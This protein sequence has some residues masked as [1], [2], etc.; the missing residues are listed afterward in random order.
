VAGLTHGVNSR[1]FSTALD[2]FLFSYFFIRRFSTE[3]RL[4]ITG[5][6]FPRSKKAIVATTIAQG[7]KKFDLPVRN[8]EDHRW[9]A[10]YPKVLAHPGRGRL[11]FPVRDGRSRREYLT[12]NPRSD[13]NNYRK[14]VDIDDNHGER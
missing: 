6:R 4:K 12:V 8:E 13:R 7:Q 14:I 9:V 11:L 3:L 10:N 1:W 2:L 5:D